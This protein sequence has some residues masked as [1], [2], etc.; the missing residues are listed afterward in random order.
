MT[1]PEHD[2]AATRA[3]LLAHWIELRRRLM[4]CAS[5]YLLSVAVCYHFAPQIYAF[6]VQPLADSF[7]DPASR[8]MIYTSLIEAFFT[9][10][11]LAMFGGI[12][13]GFPVIAAQLYVF[14][15]PGLYK[16]ERRAFLPYLIAAPILFFTGAALVYYGIFPTAWKFFLSFEVSPG[17]GQLPIQLEAKVSEYLSL[18]TQLLVAFGVSFQLPLLMVLLTHAGLVKAAAWARTRRYALVAIVAFAAVI[19]PPD[20]FSQ[21]ALSIP[22]YVLY[23]LSLHLCRAIE[24]KREKKNA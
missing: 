13:L 4:I 3:S 19:T 14:V 1:S 10:L 12:F 16:R 21:I 9:Y 6:L 5:A 11:K 18:V 8:R 17:Q 24:S 7:P 2:P 22:L 15:A 23:E 20:V